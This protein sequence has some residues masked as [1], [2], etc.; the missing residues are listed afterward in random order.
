MPSGQT[1]HTVTV[2]AHGQ[3]VESVQPGDRVTLT[4]IFRAQVRDVIIVRSQTDSFCGFCGQVKVAL[5]Q[6]TKAN[7]KQRALTSVYR[8]NVDALHFRKTDRSRLH[9]D[10]G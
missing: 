1:P 10:N 4:G 7:P 9:Q 8:T 5:L 3:L 2:F 6:A